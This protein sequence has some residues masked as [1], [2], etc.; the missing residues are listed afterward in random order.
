MYE[1]PASVESLVLAFQGG[2]ESAMD[3]LVERLR[4]P[5]LRIATWI[6][7]DPVAAEDIF[8]ESMAR[9]LTLLSDFD[10]PA[11][12]DAYA[13]RTVRNAAVDTIRRRSDRDSLRSLRDTDRIARARRKEPG[14]FVEGMPGTRPGPEQTLIMNERRR[15]V[16]AAVSGLRE[17]GRTMVEM[18]YREERSYDDIA[19]QLDV[20][21]ATVKR[22]L[23]VARQ[24]LAVRLQGM[25]EG[26]RV[27]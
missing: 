3:R 15:Q 6:V 17:P 26:R 2:D 25:E 4:A 20:S 10:T 7:R 5:L 13:K 22:H 8:S 16:Q 1:G 9:L 14:T 23:A 19:E 11:K 27:S 24:L 18:F 21:P 12:F